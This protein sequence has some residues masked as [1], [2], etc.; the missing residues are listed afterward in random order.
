[1]RPN[2][3]IFVFLLAIL[4]PLS[5]GFN[6]AQARSVILAWS[7]VPQTHEDNSPIAETIYYRVYMGPTSRNY[8][9]KENANLI[10]MINGEVVH[11]RIV[12]FADDANVFIAVTA[13]YTKA[14][15]PPVEKESGYSN[16]VTQMGKIKLRPPGV[17]EIIGTK[18]DSN[19][20]D[21]IR[22]AQSETEYELF[23]TTEQ[24]LNLRFDEMGRPIVPE[25]IRKYLE[26]RFPK[27]LTGELIFEFDLVKSGQSH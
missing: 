25:T 15:T 26:S 5:L 4:I 19:Q 17:P 23:G 27:L 21:P 24:I 12:P 14:Q 22:L 13:Y 2:N 1:M 20:S 3:S 6:T 10:Q 18:D 16:E 7:P 11:E 9:V 8:T